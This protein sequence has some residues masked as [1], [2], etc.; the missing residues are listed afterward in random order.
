M[1]KLY[2]DLLK[3]LREIAFEKGKTSLV[4]FVD[5]FIKEVD[6]KNKKIIIHVIEGLL[7]E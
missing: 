3:V 7:W 2:S 6:I 1:S 4:P 5:E